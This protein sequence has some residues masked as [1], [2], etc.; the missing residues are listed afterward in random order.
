VSSPERL[1]I[2]ARN[3]LLAELTLAYPHAY[4]SALRSN[5][6]PIPIP[7]AI[8]VPP[9]SPT[10]GRR[11]FFELIVPDDLWPAMAAWDQ[12]RASGSAAV[13]L[14]LASDPEH[15]VEVHVIDLTEEH[16]V[17]LEFVI[18]ELGANPWP[19]RA[20]TEN[21]RARVATMRKDN[22][23]IV[24]SIDDAVTDMLGWTPEEMIGHR[25]VEFTDPDH[26][27]LAVTTFVDMLR[28]PGSSR[29]TRIRFRRSDGSWLWVEVTNHNL[30]GESDDGY[31]LAELVDVSE[32]MAYQEA[33][34]SREEL[35]RRLTDALPLG[36]LHVDLTGRV[37][38]RNE[39]LGA[40]L[41][42]RDA[43]TLQDQ[44]ASV[45]EADKAI[46]DQLLEDVRT[47]ALD[48]DVDLVI[49]DD[50]ET[51][52]CKVS[53]R[54]LKGADGEPAGA[55]IAV[56]DV[57]ESVR[58]RRELER[59]ATTDSLTGCHTRSSIMSLLEHSLAGGRERGVGTGVIFIDLD[60]FKHVN[61]QYGH[62]VGDEYLARVAGRLLHAVRKR[63]AVG[64]LGGD[65]FLVLCD[66]V[67]SS[68][69]LS[70]V[71][72]RI[73]DQLQRA[74]KV[75]DIGEPLPLYAS[76]GVAWSAQ[77]QSKPD[78]LVALADDAMYAVKRARRPIADPTDIAEMP[79]MSSVACVG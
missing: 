72:M 12:A 14:R 44:F 51:R 37:L 70:E 33:L 76:I 20:P 17:F 50:G 79:T 24:L 42:H 43:M 27:T 13:R 73:A 18:T 1:S 64:R 57:T 63:D 25:T 48:A 16:G 31:V 71:A 6:I 45:Q 47:A 56:S 75:S 29:R 67:S 49:D 41:G 28:N 60:R 40:I 39:Q 32:E 22:Q 2:A 74:V 55:V 35:L 53:L 52:Q 65:E 30:L 36:M 38:Y 58:M 10:D 11:T 5:G 7:D 66:T 4:I 54:A 62:A 46:V 19:Q 21:A 34:R 68:E 3:Q 77:S 23:S 59:R 69:Q 78:D 8:D 61:D 9:Q 15:Y 26:L